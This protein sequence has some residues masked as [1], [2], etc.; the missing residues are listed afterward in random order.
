MSDVL[1]ANAEYAEKMRSILKL[2]HEPV[3]VKLIREGEKYPNGTTPPLL[4]LSHCQ[5]VFR[6]K[7]GE[8]LSVPLAMNNCHVGAAVLGMTETPEKVAN[9]E[10][11]G[12]TGIHDS[13]AAAKH[14]I[15]HRIMIPYKTVG[16][17][18]CP[19][20]KADFVPDA[21]VFVDIPE[22]I[23]WIAAMST[24]EKGNRVVFSTAP[25]QCACEDV[26]AM[27]IVEGKPNLSLGCFGC[28]KKTDMEAD[29]L[30][31]GVPYKL[32]PGYVARLERYSS[33]P[34]AKAKRD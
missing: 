9:G 27:P 30:A 15:D 21:I 6:A 26:V 24:A 8:C 7:E 1:K 18:V 22:R 2:R 31:C 3:A 4:Q 28:R 11:H 32:I 10:F 33:G 25:F 29:E 13:V 34:I 5:A 19:L 17:A 16:E 12:G 23:Y 20:G 14:M